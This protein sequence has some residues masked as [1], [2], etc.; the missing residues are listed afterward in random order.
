M[1]KIANRE[2]LKSNLITLVKIIQDFAQQVEN[3]LPESKKRQEISTLVSSCKQ[4][5]EK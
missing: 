1:N 4:S 2:K 5:R 3:N